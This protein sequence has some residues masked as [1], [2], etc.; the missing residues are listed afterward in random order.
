MGLSFGVSERA[1]TWSGG[2]TAAQLVD[3]LRLLDA[4]IRE[5]RFDSNAFLRVRDGFA[6]NYDTIFNTP[7][8]VFGAFANQPIHGGDSRYALPTKAQVAAVTADAYRAFWQPLFAGGARKVLII[9]DIDMVAAI[10]AA[11]QTFGAAATKPAVPVPPSHLIVRPPVP[12]KAP[13]TLAHRGDPNQLLIATLWSTSGSLQD[14]KQMRAL[15]VAAQI[16]QTRLYDRF[17][18]T[19][20]GTYSPSVRSNQSETF[21]DF[22][23]FLATSQI[24]AERQA[25]FERATRE[26]T[27]ALAKDG[28][29]ADELSRA[30]APIAS[31]NDRQR[32]LN[33]YWAQ[34]LQGNL[35]DPRYVE[36]IRTGVTGY[37]QVTAEQ[38]RAAA[39]RWLTREPALRILVKGAAAKGS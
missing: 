27:Q 29:S 15:N 36:M 26:V 3:Q 35:D 16:I 9:G 11:R 8:S 6:Q 12:S 21:P 32:K 2:T 7:G 34:M 19:E 23:V 37:Q 13:L 17:R 24:K 20:G 5:P 22:G 31:N 33:P 1:F 25:D 28:P 38:V 4:A 18:E 30:I 10:E 14:L 39:Q